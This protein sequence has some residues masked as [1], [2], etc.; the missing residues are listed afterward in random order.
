MD[1]AHARHAGNVGDVFKHVALTAVLE[2][3]LKDPLPLRYVESHAGDGMFPLG[4]NG[5]WSA[6]IQLLWEL[7]GQDAAGRFVELVRGFSGPDATRPGKYPGSP[8]IAQ[9]LLRAQD[10]LLL[11]ELEPQAAGVLRRTLA[12]DARAEVRETDGLAALP[13]ALPTGPEARAFVLVDPPYTQKGEWADTAA[14]VIEARKGGAMVAVWYPIKA[15]TRPRALLSALVAGGLHGT[16]VEL[17]ST[18]LRLKREKLNGSGMLLLGVPDA[19]VSAL[20][21]VLPRLGPLV[22]THGEWSSTQIG[23]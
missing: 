2:E 16:L 3:L 21:A 22:A 13:A 17:I 9:K 12:A 15:L 5:E 6:G 18:P 20:C 14:A 11:H 8:V 19:A 10:S 4:S 1:Y 23:F 7:K